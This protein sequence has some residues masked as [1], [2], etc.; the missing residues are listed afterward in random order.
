MSRK[1]VPIPTTEV[2]TP[3]TEVNP[4]PTLVLVTNIGYCAFN[5]LDVSFINLPLLSGLTAL[6]KNLI[7][8]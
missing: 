4:V 8:N 1:D 2:S 5:L 3:F 7:P 6:K